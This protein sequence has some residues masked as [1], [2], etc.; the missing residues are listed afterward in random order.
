MPKKIIPLTDQ[1]IS[2][3]KPKDKQYSIFDGGGLFVLVTPSGG[4]FGG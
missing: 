1:K 4:S 3:A 2:K